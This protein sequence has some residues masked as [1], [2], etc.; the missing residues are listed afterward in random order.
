MPDPT[1]IKTVMAFDFG[2]GSIGVAVGT[3]L[4]AEGQALQAL[5]ARDGIPDWHQIEQLLQQWQPQLLVVGLP[6]NMD[7]SDSEMSQRARKFGNRLH[8][9]YGLPVAMQDERL[10]TREAKSRARAEGH[11]GNYA[12]N[13][14]D[15][16]AAQ[17]ILQDWYYQN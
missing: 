11:R 16:L 13:P 7:G 5:R 6:L 4:T 8:G 1:S 17:A 14:I 10:T 15:S 3:G 12:E 9:R 2:T